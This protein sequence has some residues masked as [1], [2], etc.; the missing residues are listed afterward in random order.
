M[1]KF[2]IALLM[3]IFCMSTIA[4]QKGT[5]EPDYY[6]MGYSGDTWTGEVTATDE[7]KREITLIYKKKDKE[8]TFVGILEEGYSVKMKDGSMHKLKVSEIPAGTKIKVYYVSKNDKDAS[9]SKVK[10][11]YIFKVK[12]LPKDK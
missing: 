4:V 10:I 9:G 8:E 6:P 11:N 1:K 7:S 2:I 3:T 12:F 5:A